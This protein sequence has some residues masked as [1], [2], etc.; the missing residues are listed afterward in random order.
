MWQAW[1]LTKNLEFSTFPLTVFLFLIQLAK[2]HQK[3]HYDSLINRRSSKNWM[4]QVLTYILYLPRNLNMMFTYIKYKVPIEYFCKCNCIVLFHFVLW[5][6]R[7]KLQWNIEKWCMKSFKC[8]R[9]LS[10]T[11]SPQTIPS[12]SSDYSY[13]VVLE[14]LIITGGFIINE[15]YYLLTPC[16]YI[17][18]WSSR[19]LTVNYLWYII[20]TNWA[21][22]IISFMKYIHVWYV[23]KL[24]LPI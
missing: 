24:Y 22:K 2:P 15:V 3:G 17:L 12:F 7:L 21:S 9:I 10:Y 16:H 11:N 18:I 8:V 23:S 1:Y 20:V 4:K 14:I 13:L 5:L 6:S 19:L